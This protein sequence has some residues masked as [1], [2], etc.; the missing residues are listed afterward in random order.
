MPDQPPSSSPHM[1]EWETQ[2]SPD[3]KNVSSSL[4]SISYSHMFISLLYK[5]QWEAPWLQDTSVGI[6][7]Y[8]LSNDMERGE[9]DC[10]SVR[11]QYYFTGCI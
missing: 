1:G 7:G 10:D 11:Q 8:F 6:V 4:Q 5:K 3:N 2:F 9:P